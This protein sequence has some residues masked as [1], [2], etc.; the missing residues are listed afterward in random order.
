MLAGDWWASRLAGRAQAVHRRCAQGVTTSRRARAAQAPQ[1]PPWRSDPSTCASGWSAASQGGACRA[2]RPR[3][4]PLA[5]QGLGFTGC[6]A[7]R[8]PAPA[9]LQAADRGRG[10]LQLVTVSAANSRPSSDLR[11]SGGRFGEAGPGPVWEQRTPS[12]G[13]SAE[14]GG[15]AARPHSSCSVSRRS[16]SGAASFWLPATQQDILPGH[17][18]AG[19]RPAPCR[20]HQQS[21]PALDSFSSCQE[22]RAHVG[23]ARRDLRCCRAAQLSWRQAIADIRRAQRGLDGAHLTLCRYMRAHFLFF[24]ASSDSLRTHF[25]QAALERSRVDSRGQM[26][27][28][29]QVAGRTAGLA[30]TGGLR[31]PSRQVGCCS[32]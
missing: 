13:V 12:A 30:L 11:Q 5:G 9:Q 4:L 15:S 17:A 16:P 3:A 22:D 27:D 10:S 23:T 18:E 24:S 32:R 20:R 26:H 28:A 2:G 7:G 25:E 1:G 6:G 31:R 19:E 21:P 14:G 29:F 8:L